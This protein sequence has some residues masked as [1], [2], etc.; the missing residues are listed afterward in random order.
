LQVCINS[1]RFIAHLVNQQV[2]HEI[3]ALEIVTLLLEKATDDSVEVAIGFLKE[4][5]QKLDEVSPKGL[6]AVSDR[7]R[8]ILHEQ[9][10]ADRTQYLI[11]SCFA[12]IKDKFKVCRRVV[13]KF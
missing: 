5:G 2:A 1:S 7:M 13:L 9:Q 6:R 10:V 4:C 11:E 8:H 3:L 12:T